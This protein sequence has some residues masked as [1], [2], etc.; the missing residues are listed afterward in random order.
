MCAQGEHAETNST[1]KANAHTKGK[2]KKRKRKRKIG[3]GEE[4]RGDQVDFDSTERGDEKCDDDKRKTVTV[5]RLMALTSHLPSAGS[6]QWPASP[7]AGAVL[8][9]VSS[10]SSCTMY[11]PSAGEIVDHFL[12]KEVCLPFLPDSR[13]STLTFEIVPTTQSDPGAC[14]LAMLTFM[15]AISTSPL[16][17]SVPICLPTSPYPNKPPS[18]SRAV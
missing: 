17:S 12:H 1:Q 8:S 2:D 9:S 18:L 13:V 10:V 11:S 4:E 5:I 14:I 16:S 7:S 3:R 15:V 6:Q